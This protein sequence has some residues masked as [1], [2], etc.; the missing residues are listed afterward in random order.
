MHRAF[1][2]LHVQSSNRCFSVDKYKTKDK[3]N[4][5]TR[6]VNRMYKDS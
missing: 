5:A 3:P 4:T 6:E 1:H 2:D